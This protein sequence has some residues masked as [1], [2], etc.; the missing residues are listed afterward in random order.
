M[1]K[2]LLLET[3]STT[4]TN[5]IKEFMQEYL[6]DTNISVDFVNKFDRYFKNKNFN[7]NLNTS[8][9]T[10][11]SECKSHLNAEY[12]NVEFKI[13][14]QVFND[15]YKEIQS[16]S[17]LDNVKSLLLANFNTTLKMYQDPK[18]VKELIAKNRKN[19]T[20]YYE[21]SSTA[22]TIKVANA[23]YNC[24]D[25]LHALDVFKD[26]VIDN[27]DKYEDTEEGFNKLIDDNRDPVSNNTISSFLVALVDKLTSEF[28]E[29][30]KIDAEQLAE[31]E[32][33]QMEQD[34]NDDISIEFLQKIA[35]VIRFISNELIDKM[36]EGERYTDSEV[37]I[38][39]IINN[40]YE[41]CMQILDTATEISNKSKEVTQNLAD[42]VDNFIKDTVELSKANTIDNKLVNQIREAAAELID[43]NT[44]NRDRFFYTTKIISIINAVTNKVDTI[45]YINSAKNRLE[46]Y[47]TSNESARFMLSKLMILTAII[48]IY[49][50]SDDK[51]D[52]SIVDKLVKIVNE[53]ISKKET[54]AFKLN[55]STK[56]DDTAIETLNAK[57]NELVAKATI[58]SNGKTSAITVGDRFSAP[59]INSAKELCDENTVLKFAK[60]MD[61]TNYNH[62]FNSNTLNDS[63]NV[64]VKAQRRNYANSLSRNILNV[65][66]SAD[67]NLDVD[68]I[69]TKLSGF[70]KQLSSLHED[71]ETGKAGKTVRNKIFT[72]GMAAFDPIANL[73]RFLSPLFRLVG[74]VKENKLINPKNENVMRDSDQ[75]FDIIELVQ[76][77][78][79]APTDDAIY[80]TLRTLKFNLDAASNGLNM[81]KSEIISNDVRKDKDTN[82]R[83]EVAKAI[84]KSSHIDDIAQAIEN[85]ELI[86]SVHNITSIAKTLNYITL[87]ISKSEGSLTANAIS[88]SI[89][90]NFIVAK[91]VQTK[92]N[93]TISAPEA[94]TEVS[95]D[96]T[97]RSFVDKLKNHGSVE[98]FTKLLKAMS[99]HAKTPEQ[100]YNE[101]Y[102]VIASSYSVITAG[103]AKYNFILGNQQLA[104]DANELH[105][106]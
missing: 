59:I 53:Q 55:A 103:S 80:N 5:S 39:A 97:V 75:F 14:N 58:S 29:T 8:I 66:K 87:F 79:Y 11:I 63:D 18:K 83:I 60:L 20:Y 21:E 70:A 86:I 85:A 1:L 65:V 44:E 7:I 73:K 74:K 50:G 42:A 19:E 84:F 24:S 25:V 27:I 2:K 28:S 4:S 40:V 76:P 31:I 12:S 99:S 36:S 90:N 61:A 43:Q 10:I 45:K 77:R 82:I 104:P 68:S 48:S 106:S 96:P 105:L 47:P 67:T 64:L 89:S 88:E 6:A 93:S 37:F 98:D 102:D 34:P 57:V 16:A 72:N 100:F 13:D 94:S 78:Q 17:A 46:F 9:P 52:T 54:A 41:P 49:M 35:T 91:D 81:I 51:A 33:E 22:S 69:R 62:L 23:L 26:S 56:K 3:R 15:V 92:T 95:A 71:I 32:A 101:V 38:T 30:N